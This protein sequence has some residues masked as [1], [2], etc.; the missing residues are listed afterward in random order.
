MLVIVGLGL[1]DLRDLSLG[2]FDTLRRASK[3]FVELYTS[4]VPG[5]KLEE[6]EKL[7]G[8][9]VEV[10]HRHQLEG[11]WLDELMETAKRE[12]VA[13]VVP[14]DPF[15]ATTH[16]TIKLEA[17]KRG[18]KVA[19]YPAPSIINAVIAS[20]GLQIYKFGR[21]VTIVRQT[22]LYSPVTPYY[23]LYENLRRGL[24]T[25]FFLDLNVEEGYAMTAVE[26]VEVLRSIEER[27]GLGL[28][29]EYTPFIAVARAS[30]PDEVVRVIRL[31]EKADLG[32][33]PHTLIVPGLLNPVEL[34]ALSLL[35]GASTDLLSRWHERV[36]DLAASEA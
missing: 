27:E 12:D 25:L 24:H 3:V 28:I 26:G 1:Y 9:Q 11:K 20:T 15:I 13:L 33:A 8:R 6:L 2:A 32:P 35:A 23:V 19:V 36:R 31:S 17:I 18:I 22:P 21:P 16:I 29:D 5:F 7:L 14:G 10:V 30:S 34:E 4:I